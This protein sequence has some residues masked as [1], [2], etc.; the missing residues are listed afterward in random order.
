VKGSIILDRKVASTDRQEAGEAT[1]SALAEVAVAGEVIVVVEVDTTPG[2]D[3]RIARQD[4]A[5]VTWKCTITMP[6]N[7]RK[8]RRR[9]MPQSGKKTTTMRKGI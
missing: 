7:P 5:P 4:R 1:Q 8:L 9:I 6:K 3:I 2:L